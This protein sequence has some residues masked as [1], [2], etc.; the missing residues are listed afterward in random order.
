[1]TAH[2]L[3]APVT[4]NRDLGG[5]YF[6]TSLLAPAIARE[7]RPGQFLMA[8]SHRP[9]ELL[10][11]RP[12]SVCLA[13][14]KEGVVSILYRVVG[15]GTALFSRTP[16]GEP[17]TLLGPLGAGFSTPGAAEQP[18]LVMGGI[19][20]AAF[21]FLVEDLCGRGRRPRILYGAR[22]GRDLPMRDWFESRARTD[23]TTDDGSAGEQG[24]VTQP[25]RRLLE[26]RPDANGTPHLYTC[27]PDPMMRAVARIAAEFGVAAEAALETPMAC[28]Y[29][30]C[31]GCVVEVNEPQGEYGRYKRVCVDGPVFPTADVRW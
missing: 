5:G 29:G 12:F 8:G 31:L 18:V 27:G 24:L 6:L 1:M 30:V 17:L 2:D 21:P 26:G 23:V 14:P 22:T 13:D 4:S 15:R 3:R 9:G 20:S 19:G 7:A 10:L 28:G 25:L 11:R 16:A